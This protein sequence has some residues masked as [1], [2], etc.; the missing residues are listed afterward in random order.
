[1]VVEGLLQ[2]HHMKGWI[3]GICL[4]GYN[5][6]VTQHVGYQIIPYQTRHYAV[7]EN[8]VLTVL[9]HTHYGSSSL[10]TFTT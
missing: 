7:R 5:L 3:G 10:T 8:P 4:L 6:R 9:T 2:V 1:M